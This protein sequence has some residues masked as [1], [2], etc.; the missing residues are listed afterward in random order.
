MNNRD[1]LHHEGA[2]LVEEALLSFTAPIG[3]KDLYPIFCE[4]CSLE[5]PEKE[6]SDSLFWDCVLLRLYLADRE[7][8]GFMS[9]FGCLSALSEGMAESLSHLPETLM[10][11]SLRRELDGSFLLAGS[12]I[13][14]PSEERIRE[15]FHFF[16]ELEKKSGN[17]ESLL[18]AFLQFHGIP[19]SNGLASFLHGEVNAFL[20][21]L[22]KKLCR[23]TPCEIS[24]NARD[25]SVLVPSSGCIEA[26]DSSLL[27]FITSLALCWLLFL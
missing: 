6:F 19:S 8:R 18:H 2:S 7:I 11:L 23:F 20:L 15:R 3:K 17:R 22:H 4:T 26:V 10:A 24:K 9:G 25:F 16:G 21:A 14:Y 27:A 5:Y 1:Y 13:S 12:R